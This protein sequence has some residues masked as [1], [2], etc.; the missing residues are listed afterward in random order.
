MRKGILTEFGIREE[1]IANVDVDAT[2]VVGSLKKEQVL[3]VVSAYM[4][5]IE[6]C[7]ERQLQKE[8]QLHGTVLM[9]V[10]INLSGSVK[11]ATLQNSTIGSRIVESCVS[12]VFR[13]MPFPLQNVPSE[14]KVSIKFNKDKKTDKP[15]QS[16]SAE[17]RTF[18][19]RDSSFIQDLCKDNL[20]FK[21]SSS[22]SNVCALKTN[23]KSEIAE[24]SVS[25]GKSYESILITFKK[26]NDEYAISHLHLN[27]SI[28]IIPDS[29]G[30][31][32]NL[33][34]LR[35]EILINVIP[36]SIQNLV[37]L[38]RLEVFHGGQQVVRIPKWLTKLTNLTT[39]SISNAS[40][41]DVP[42]LFK[43]LKNLKELSLP[44][45]IY[46]GFPNYFIDLK[47]LPLEKFSICCGQFTVLPKWINELKSLKELDISSTKITTLP[48]TIGNLGN[49][50]TLRLMFNRNFS[51]VPDSICNLQNLQALELNE[52]NLSEVPECLGKLKN[53]NMLR[54]SK[55]NLKNLP[56]GITELTNLNHLYFDDNPISSIPTSFE[57]FKSN[58]NL[59]NITAPEN[60]SEK[61]KKLIKEIEESNRRRF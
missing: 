30:S 39:L 61:D 55:N 23:S 57:K 2:S 41:K 1:G 11:N 8:P 46:Y 42:D 60:L 50:E 16:Q 28:T 59:V 22:F 33:E 54:L 6:Y 37:Q 10:E 48:D 40:F 15:S 31:L 19:S 24:F 9:N 25:D 26:I 20:S 47:D 13:R 58:Q 56:I 29:I 51:G 35:I 7:Y 32:K 27:E 3:K 44:R 43:Y 4:G 17:L 38:N 52:N 21:T 49:L 5:Q 12:G 45:T 53:L 14:A 18:K 34:A 36:D